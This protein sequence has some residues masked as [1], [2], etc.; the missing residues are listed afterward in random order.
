MTTSPKVAKKAGALLPK[1]SQL[2]GQKESEAS[3]LSQAARK[4]KRK[5]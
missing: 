2:K 1:K 3:A 4:K 5:P